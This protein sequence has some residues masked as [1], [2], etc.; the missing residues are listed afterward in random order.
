MSIEDITRV[1][2]TKAFTLKN[3][4]DLIDKYILEYSE[5]FVF[6]FSEHIS[7]NIFD[8]EI[9]VDI[10][11]ETYGNEIA[12]HTLEH[13]HLGQLP[14]A[15]TVC[16]IAEDRRKRAFARKQICRECLL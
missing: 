10:F 1:H 8:V 16:Q 6:N 14:L 13:L 12:V 7:K 11:G 9:E 5:N 15:T 2:V 3:L 4:M